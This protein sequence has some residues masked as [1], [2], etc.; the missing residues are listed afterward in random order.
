MSEAGTPLSPVTYSRHI[1]YMQ[2]PLSSLDSNTDSDN[3]MKF[4][5]MSVVSYRPSIHVRS[6][7]VTV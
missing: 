4:Y 6:R 1:A 5:N 2:T 3:I 7:A